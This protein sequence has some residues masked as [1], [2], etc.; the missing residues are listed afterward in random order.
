MTCSTI[1]RDKWAQ[2]LENWLVWRVGERTRNNGGAPISSIYSGQVYRSTGYRS[3][4]PTVLE[5]EARDTDELMHLLQSDRTAAHLYRV[6]VEW[7]R[8]EGTRG[9]QAGRLGLPERTYYTHADLAVAYLEMAL[10]LKRRPLIFGSNLLN[11]RYAA[12]TAP[13]SD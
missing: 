6:A 11:C 7:V 13:E 9:A 4:S 12:T 5:G 8:N 2:R 3:K 10:R 1:L